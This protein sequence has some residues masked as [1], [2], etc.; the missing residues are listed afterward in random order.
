MMLWTWSCFQVKLR[1]E[2]KSERRWQSLPALRLSLA[3]AAEL[4]QDIILSI[5]WKSIHLEPIQQHTL[6]FNYQN[7]SRL[8]KVTRPFMKL[9][10]QL[11]FFLAACC[12]DALLG[13]QALVVQVGERSSS[14]LL[15]AWVG[16][17]ECLHRVPW[18]IGKAPRA[19]T[20]I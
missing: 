7:S 8:A 5:K 16:L 9:V 10:T 1:T 20:A 19:K 4:K 11:T 3:D 2:A 6:W 12:W 17:A 15:D 13:E 18:P 14:I